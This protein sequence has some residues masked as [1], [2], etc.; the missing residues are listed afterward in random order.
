MFYFESHVQFVFY[1]TSY[2]SLHIKTKYLCL[3][4]FGEMASCLQGVR[5]SA[6]PFTAGWLWTSCLTSLGIIFVSRGDGSI[7]PT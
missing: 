5:I 6:P 1:S 7:Y 3:E 2:L 4:Y